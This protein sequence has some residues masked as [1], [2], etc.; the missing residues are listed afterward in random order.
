MPEQEHLEIWPENWRIVEVFSG[1]ETQWNYSG[2]GGRPIGMRYESLPV[3]L[4]AVSIPPAE[5]PEV[6][7]GL[8]LM[9]RATLD[10]VNRG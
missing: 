8:R 10:E 5:R 3:V 4:D 1:M 2:M 9:E 6:F 7:A